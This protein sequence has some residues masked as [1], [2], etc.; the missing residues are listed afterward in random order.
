MDDQVPSGRCVLLVLTAATLVMAVVSG[1]AFLL[2]RS[3]STEEQ[4]LLGAIVAVVGLGAAG[5]RQDH[6]GGDGLR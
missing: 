5:L 6:G 3:I 4:L 2:Q 1:G